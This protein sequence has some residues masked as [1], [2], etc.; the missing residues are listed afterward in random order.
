MRITLAQAKEFENCVRRQN[1]VTETQHE[2]CFDPLDFEQEAPKRIVPSTYTQSGKGLCELP[3]E[4]P[5]KVTE[6]GNM[7]DVSTSLNRSNGKG[8]RK[9][10]KL[11]ATEYV[12]T[13]TGEVKQYRKNENRTQ[14]ISNLN[15]SIKEL[16]RLILCNF[17]D[18]EGLFITLAYDSFMDDY[19]I[20]C[21]DYTKFYDK[22]KYYCK[23]RFGVG[24]LLYIR[25][26]EPKQSG[27]WHFHILVK[28][29]DGT[30][31][32]I[33]EDNLRKMWGQ[34]SVKVDPITNVNG[35]ALYLGRTTKPANNAND[36]DGI[37][38]LQDDKTT[39]DRRKFYCSGMK[40]YTP[41]TG[42]KRPVKTTMTQE[43]AAQKVD[44]YDKIDE[45]HSIVRLRNAKKAGQ[46]INITNYE[47]FKEKDS[48]E[49]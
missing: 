9:T 10:K 30:A 23:S 5:A 22:F 20:V 21:Q 38:M 27:S 41:S 8:L 31:I 47:T 2:I 48:F 13:E 33:S 34:N 36:E 46:V 19:D 26:T 28:S 49:S 3:E 39:R 18:G 29:K 14:S 7:I 40:L 1:V 6:Y 24:D 45:R 16:K 4:C 15:Q 43:E 11:S 32:E 25:V 37:F 12:D 17:S 42:L 35:L 44:G